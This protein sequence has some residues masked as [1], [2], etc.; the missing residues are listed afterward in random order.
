MSYRGQ[1]T[2]PGHFPFWARLLKGRAVTCCRPGRENHTLLSIRRPWLRAA[3][4]KSGLGLCC[5]L[6][7]PSPP[8]R[9][10]R[11]GACWA[12]TGNSYGFPQWVTSKQDNRCDDSESNMETI[13]NKTVNLPEMKWS[14]TRKFLSS[15]YLSNAIQV[16]KKKLFT[17]H[18]RWKQPKFPPT[19][20]Q[21]TICRITMNGILFSHRKGQSTD[22]C[23]SPYFML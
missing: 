9:M 14:D 21:I 7:P 13:Q 5:S 17:I 8:P 22:T 4:S 18:K 23:M 1:R 12:Q 20:K 16:F 15:D 10:V 19:C 2:K 11:E 6:Q 3:S